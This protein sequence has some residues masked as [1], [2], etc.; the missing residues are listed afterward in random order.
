M[1]INNWENYD[2]SWLVEAAKIYAVEYPWLI[3]AL[4]KCI[5]AKK[6]NNLYTYFVDASKPNEPGSEWQFQENII[7]ENTPE[8]EIAIDI[9]K[10]NRVGGIEFLTRIMNENN[11]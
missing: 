11:T 7:L 4:E 3:D 6:R 8:G 10:N 9:I 2:P 5:K 1:T